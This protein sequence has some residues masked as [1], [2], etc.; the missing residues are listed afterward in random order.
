MLEVVAAWPNKQQ[1][2]LHLDAAE[3]EETACS[4]RRAIRKR[5][6]GSKR[7]RAGKEKQEQK[8]GVSEG[9]THRL[10]K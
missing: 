5:G 10:R 8:A 2:V 7:L 6:H 4:T 3:L 9:Q 1:R